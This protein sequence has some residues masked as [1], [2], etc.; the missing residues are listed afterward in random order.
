M[1]YMPCNCIHLQLIIL[2]QR[3]QQD[4]LELL[5]KLVNQ[6]FLVKKVMKV[7]RVSKEMLE[8]KDLWDKKGSLGSRD[9]LALKGYQDP[10]DFQDKMERKVC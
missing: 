2:G 10:M 9:C 1:Y 7:Q 5:V 8:K 6:D 3:V 4:C